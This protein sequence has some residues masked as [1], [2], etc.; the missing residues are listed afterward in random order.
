MRL[1][2]IEIVADRGH[3]K[4]PMRSQIQGTY[5]IPPISTVV[6]ILQN[7]YGEEIDDFTLGYIIEYQG[8][9]KEIENVVKE[10]NT[11]VKKL[12]DSK[13][14][15]TTPATFEYLIEPRL[16]IYTDIDKPLE[17]KSVLNLG[18]T[19]CLAKLTEIKEVELMDQ[20]GKG[21]NQYVSMNLVDYGMPKRINTLT[22]YN[23]HKGYYDIFSE[24]V[25]ESEEFDFDKY[26][27]AEEEQNIFL[28][29]WNK[30]GILNELS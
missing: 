26:Y 19:N 10:I 18:K 27:D 29:K 2:K 7:L 8:V 1:N 13:R 28:W 22:K 21:F 25:V 16:V 12:T 14:F 20:E 23:E 9:H 11:N 5:L 3:F 17:L 4:I 24:V 15:I 6:G 30:G